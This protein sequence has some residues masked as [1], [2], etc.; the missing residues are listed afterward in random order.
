VK[1]GIIGA[2]HIGGTLGELFAARG[3]DVLYGVREGSDAPGPKGS[4]AEAAAHGEV[5]IIAVPGRAIEETIGAAGDLSGKVVVDTC[6]MGGDPLQSSAE[7]IAGW[8][9]GARVVKSFNQA[10]WETLNEPVL[11]GHRAVMFAAGDDEDARKTVI[12][13]GNELGLEMVDAGPLE[14]ARLLESMAL[15]W[16][17]LAFRGGQG[18][19]TAFGLLRRGD[20]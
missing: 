8:A 3:H 7:K 10:G 5:V 4:I 18:R 12:G 13:L 1:I 2:G 15:L 20:Q 11:E 9:L 16:I 14:N 17:Y 19:G 6:N